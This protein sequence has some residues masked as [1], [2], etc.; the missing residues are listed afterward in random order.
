MSG[1]PLPRKDRVP[2]SPVAI[3]AGLGVCLLWAYWPTLLKLEN[4]WA[5]DPQSSHGFLVPLFAFIVLW[6]RR[7]SLPARPWTIQ[8]WGLAFVVAAGLVRLGGGYLHLDWFDGFSLLVSLAGVIVLAGDWPLLRWAAP[9]LV[10][11]LFMLPLPYQVEIALAG[12]LQRAATVAATYALQTLGYPAV[13]EGNVIVLDAQRIEVATACNGL[14]MLSAFFA[15]STAVALLIERPRYEKCIVFASA[16]PLGVLVNLI[17]ITATGWA[18]HAFG[19]R[20]AEALFH[21]YAGW[22]MMPLALLALWL[23]LLLLKQLLV[24]KAAA[25]PVPVVLPR[26]PA[27]PATPDRSGPH[28]Q[29][30]A[31]AAPLA[32]APAPVESD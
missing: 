31:Q 4:R 26:P 15:L 12:P 17:R 25:R 16:I 14:G 27:P 30:V 22:L 13:A 18:Y 1:D 20:V 9:G 29:L 6:T 8:P 32:D 11:L 23:E 3:F 10:L 24:D 7:A 2:A 5:T 21:D 28:T 19:S